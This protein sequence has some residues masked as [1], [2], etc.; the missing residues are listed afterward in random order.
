M[1]EIIILLLLIVGFVLDLKTRRVSN[2]LTASVLIVSSPLIY[3]NLNQIT[4]YHLVPVV[5]I[6]Y[7]ILKRQIGGADVKVLVPIILFL[8]LWELWVFGFVLAVSGLLMKGKKRV[9]YFVNIVI[10][11]GS[12]FIIRLWLYYGFQGLTV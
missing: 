2:K 11:Y 5:L 4:A 9:P 6:L 1:L 3:H 12:V 10:G 7:L 8:S